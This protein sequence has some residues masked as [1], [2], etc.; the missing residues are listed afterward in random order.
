MG[1][2]I[3]FDQ[4]QVTQIIKPNSVKESGSWESFGY[5][6]SW[7]GWKGTGNN[8]L[9]KRSESQTVLEGEDQVFRR[10]GILPLGMTKNWVKMP[11]MVLTKLLSHVRI[12]QENS[13][14]FI[15]GLGTVTGLILVESPRMK[16]S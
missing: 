1:M 11:H 15:S 9:V 14:F 7:S 10:E 8:H 4:F 16:S 13:L 12:C 5:V 3:S 6:G 2:P